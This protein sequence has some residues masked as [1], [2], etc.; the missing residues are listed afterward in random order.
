MQR[1]R[2]MPRRKPP[3]PKGRKI[4]GMQCPRCGCVMKEG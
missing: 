3:Q 1:P 4:K 2:P